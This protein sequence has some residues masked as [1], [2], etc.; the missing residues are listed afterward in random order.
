MNF[1]IEGVK[2]AR[3]F[4]FLGVSIIEGCPDLFL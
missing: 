2:N 3:K 1:L 4:I